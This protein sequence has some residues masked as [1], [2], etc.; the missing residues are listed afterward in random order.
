MIDSVKA[1]SSAEQ[2]L[3]MRTP[4]KSV[5]LAVGVLLALLPSTL[6]PTSQGLVVAQAQTVPDRK[7]EADRLPKAAPLSPATA[8]SM[9]RVIAQAA[10]TNEVDK[11][12]AE[13]T[14]LFQEGSK[15]SLTA[16]ID[17]FERALQLSRADRQKA[18]R[19]L[20]LL[21]LGRIYDDLGEKVKALEYYNQALPL[22]RTVGDRGG[23]A[24]TVISALST[25]P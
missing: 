18:Q 16:A 3:S 11:A 14:R 21:A 24:T 15:A 5:G 23:E 6:F 13:G 2:D 10:P 7:T 4:L 1:Q 20:A 17:Q 19:A 25:T 12:I 22:Y 8:Q 9:A